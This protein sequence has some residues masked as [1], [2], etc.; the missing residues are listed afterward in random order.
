VK[1]A[2]LDLRLTAGSF[3]FPVLLQRRQRVRVHSITYTH[4]LLKRSR[5]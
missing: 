4:Q 2:V 1:I 3:Y 5:S